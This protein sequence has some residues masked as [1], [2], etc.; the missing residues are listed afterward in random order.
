MLAVLSSSARTATARSA[1]TAAAAIG[2]R[3]FAHAA[4]LIVSDPNPLSKLAEEES[5][6][7]EA[8]R[9]YAENEIKPKVCAERLSRS[10]CVHPWTVVEHGSTRA[11]NLRLTHRIRWPHA[12]SGQRHGPQRSAR[13]GGQ[14]WTFRA[15]CASS[16]KNVE[17]FL[18]AF[19]SK[20]CSPAHEP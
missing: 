16:S 12:H 3:R 5:Y 18:V 17:M 2:A 10:L 11:H 7:V 19:D 13:S 15:R 1:L 4:P 8:V 14:G 20:S 9:S 6:I